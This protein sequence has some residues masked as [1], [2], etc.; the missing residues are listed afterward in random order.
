MAIHST[1]RTEARNEVDSVLE[2][3]WTIAYLK[4]TLPTGQLT[5]NGPLRLKDPTQLRVLL[6]NGS[7]C[8]TEQLQD[9]LVRLELLA[10]IFPD[11]LE[12]I[13]CHAKDP[14]YKLTDADKIIAAIWRIGETKDSE[15][16]PKAYRRYLQQAFCRG[17][18]ILG[19]F[20]I[21]PEQRIAESNASL[22]E[23]N[24]IERLDFSFFPER[25]D[26]ILSAVRLE[27]KSIRIVDPV[28]S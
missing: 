19:S 14:K 5:V 16:Y 27:E 3:D 21:K 2:T 26:I 20:F 10:V 17:A 23:L 8:S 28:R 6:T 9:T 12:A 22:D 13:T 15:E 18:D 1:I 11:T 7:T 24:A 25:K 4:A